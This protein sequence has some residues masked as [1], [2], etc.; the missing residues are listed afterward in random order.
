MDIVQASTGQDE[1]AIFFAFCF[2]SSQ[3]ILEL[4]FFAIRG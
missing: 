3:K 1:E 4:P 2:P